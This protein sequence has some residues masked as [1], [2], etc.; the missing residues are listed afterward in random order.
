[1]QAQS[2]SKQR[3]EEVNF[4]FDSFTTLT[5]VV[6]FCVSNQPGYVAYATMRNGLYFDERSRFNLSTTSY[7]FSELRF[8]KT[9]LSANDVVSDRLKAQQEV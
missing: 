2:W 7:Y 6:E 3:A 5:V 8:F 4:R 1:M 9:N